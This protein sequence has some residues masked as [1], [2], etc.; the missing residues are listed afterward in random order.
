LILLYNIDKY[1]LL[2]NRNKTIKMH[3]HKEKLII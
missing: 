2:Y 1:I 3:E